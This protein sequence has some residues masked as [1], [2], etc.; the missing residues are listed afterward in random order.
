MP[1]PTSGYQ[2]F[3]GDGKLVRRLDRL[4]MLGFAQAGKIDY[5]AATVESRDF[6]FYPDSV[7]GRGSVGEIR[8]KLV[9]RSL[10]SAGKIE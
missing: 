3:Q 5:L 10:L 7:V 4:T 8:E 1:F 2:L 6:I 9:W